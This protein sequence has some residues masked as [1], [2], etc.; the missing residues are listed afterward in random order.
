MAY[1]VMALSTSPDS[2]VAG[3]SPALPP[4]VGQQPVRDTAVVPHLC[5]DM[6]VDMC[7]DA[8]VDM[9]VD[10]RTLMCVDLYSHGPIHSWPHIDM[11]LYIFMALYSHGPI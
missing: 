1:I 8:C 7:V 9:C 10:M 3:L 5:A 6:C 4:A 11:A 2:S